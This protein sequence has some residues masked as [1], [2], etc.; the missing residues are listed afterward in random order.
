MRKYTL[1]IVGMTCPHCE[2][3]VRRGLEGIP[4]TSEVT[5]DRVNG[6]AT[7]LADDRVSDV[8]LDVAVSI[9]G[10]SITAMLEDPY[11]DKDN[12]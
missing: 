3:A 8:D 2:R 4:G 10:F 7:L 1:D 9:A 12:P 5:V 6:Q 11:Y